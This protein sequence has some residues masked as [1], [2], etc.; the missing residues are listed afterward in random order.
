[1]EETHTMTRACKNCEWFTPMEQPQRSGICHADPPTPVCQDTSVYTG[2]NKIVA[3]WPA[4]SENDWCSR[5][6]ERNQEKENIA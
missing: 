2:Y 4:V 1:M 3:C 6:I 5:F